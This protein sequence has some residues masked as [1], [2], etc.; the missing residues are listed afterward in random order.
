MSRPPHYRSLHFT[1]GSC[2]LHIPG[3]G[4]RVYS[5]DAKEKLIA[6]L[7]ALR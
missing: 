7:K 1:D 2:M 5:K 4:W 6:D 3:H